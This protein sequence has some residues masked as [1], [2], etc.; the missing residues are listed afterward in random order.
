MNDFEQIRRL[1]FNEWSVINPLHDQL[2]EAMWVARYSLNNLTQSQAYLLC[3]AAEGY[4]H[5]TA[6]PTTTK[7]IIDQLR[8]VRR[9][10]RRHEEMLG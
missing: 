6:H 1:R 5:F 4:I 9:K 2:S 8:K 7:S 10:V 3:E